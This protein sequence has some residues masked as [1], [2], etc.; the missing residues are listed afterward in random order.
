VLIEQP[1][2]HMRGFGVL[3]V[4]PATSERHFLLGRREHGELVDLLQVPRRFVFESDV[5]DGRG[6]TG[7]FTGCRIYLRNPRRSPAA[8][9]RPG[10]SCPEEI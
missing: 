9:P 4:T 10:L 1:I 6:M 8:A 7:S 2:C 3:T 5:E